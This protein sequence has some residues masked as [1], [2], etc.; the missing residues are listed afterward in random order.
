M[1]RLHVTVT[2]ESQHI[3]E[4][5]DEADLAGLVQVL[6]GRSNVTLVSYTA[7]PLD[8]LVDAA[9]DQLLGSTDVPGDS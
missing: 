7:R 5:D 1:R 2:W 8:E 4:L 3:V 9:V 6:G